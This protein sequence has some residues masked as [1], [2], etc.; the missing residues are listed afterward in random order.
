[1]R[2]RTLLRGLLALAGTQASCASASGQ[3]LVV[4]TLRSTLP[5]QAVAAFKEVVEVPVRIDI[6]PAKTVAA[7]FERL[8][9]WQSRE[10]REG[11]TPFS[12]TAEP[13]S[14][15]HWISLGD[16]WL[17]AAIQQQLIRPLSVDTIP[18]WAELSEDWHPLLRRNQ[19]GFSDSTGPVWATPYRWGCCVLVYSRQAFKRLGWQPTQWQ[20]LWRDDLRDRIM[21]PNHP[22]LALAIA[23]KS[24]GY[25]LNDPNPQR[26]SDLL[27]ALE[28]L[29]K[30]VRAYGS[31]D[32]LQPLIQGDIWLAAGWSTDVRP[33]LSRYQ[34][35]G[36]VIPDPGTILSADVW[37]KP[38]GKGDPPEAT[39]LKT[40]EGQWLAHWWRQETQDLI[41]QRSAGLSP[42]LLPASAQSSAAGTGPYPGQLLLPTPAQLE[43]SEFL[44]PLTDQALQGY[45]QL[46]QQLRGSFTG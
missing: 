19:T 43:E 25:S 14:V 36:A 11:F 32:Y 23:L 34:Q 7:L 45:D 44:Y 2:R 8:R 9:A 42:R 26:H 20:D 15:D 13:G 40:I 39:S 3:T 1:M 31:T 38:K 30:Q 4:E 28:K 21:L 41:N 6:K 29:P 22:R 27:Q 18:A 35:L 33:L 17:P 12:G 16:Y 5:P 37:V 46:W 24:R 10:P